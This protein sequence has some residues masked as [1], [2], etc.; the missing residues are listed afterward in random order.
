M[1]PRTSKGFPLFCGVETALNERRART[2]RPFAVSCGGGPKKRE[3]IFCFESYVAGSDQKNKNHSYS[4]R[5]ARHRKPERQGPF[6]G[7]YQIA[8]QES[9][10]TESVRGG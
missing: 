3:R 9:L 8:P 6:A 1:G 2:D 7:A 5:Q 10:Q 4:R